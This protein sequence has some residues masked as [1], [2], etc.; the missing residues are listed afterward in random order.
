MED[1]LKDKDRQTYKIQPSYRHVS[2]FGQ[3]QIDVL[4]HGA[5]SLP[6][7]D[8]GTTPQAFVIV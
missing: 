4:L 3:E 2:G 1:P 7:T 6:N 5:S 8:D